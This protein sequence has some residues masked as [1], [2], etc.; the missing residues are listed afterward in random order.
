MSDRLPAEGRLAGIDFG[1]KRIGVAIC[2]PG[3]V[4][5]SPFATYSCRSPEADAAWFRQLVRDERIVGFVVGLPLHMSGEESAKSAAARRFGQWLAQ[6]TA[7]PV[8]YHD[9]RLSTV[10]AEQSLA[11]GHLTSK[12]RRARRDMLAA[13]VI[14]AAFLEAGQRSA[15][16]QPLED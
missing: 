5:A 11:A 10:A 12:K 3:R 6:T 9:E 7:L 13:Q 14:L 2:D 4:V 8:G 16:H 1:T 15:P